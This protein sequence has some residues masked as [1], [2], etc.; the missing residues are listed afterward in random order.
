MKKDTEL[1]KKRRAARQILCQIVDHASVNNL[2]DV[3]FLLRRL[4]V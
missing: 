2:E 4:Y 1:R 3:E